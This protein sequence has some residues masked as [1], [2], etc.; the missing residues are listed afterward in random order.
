[1]SEFQ[2][3]IDRNAVKWGNW[4]GWILS[5]QKYLVGRNPFLLDYVN[6]IHKKQSIL[7]SP[8]LFPV[9]FDFQEK[10]G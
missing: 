4:K 10:D 6:I 7:G 1:M 9:K 2:D 5:L 8:N 3:D